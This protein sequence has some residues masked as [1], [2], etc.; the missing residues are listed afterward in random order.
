MAQVFS[1]Q[2]REETL[3]PAKD[4]SAGL[5]A[6]GP[7][8]ANG[9]CMDICER[10]N[11]FADVRRWLRDEERWNEWQNL[12]VPP[13]LAKEPSELEWQKQAVEGSS[14]QVQWVQGHNPDLIV[15]NENGQEKDQVTPKL[16][17]A[18]KPKEMACC[19]C[20][21]LF[22]FGV[23]CFLG[24]FAWFFLGKRL[25]LLWL[26]GF[27]KEQQCNATKGG[28]EGIWEGG[29]EGWKDGRVEGWK[30]GRKERKQ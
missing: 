22:F 19:F 26:L 9:G 17:H 24:K 14:E 3:F 5:R 21:L 13:L 18:G 27:G 6:S 29:K 11:H 7:M 23:F 10:L 28:R 4:E 15:L 12:D 2:L 30:D 16:L 25:F 20:L 1:S 8:V